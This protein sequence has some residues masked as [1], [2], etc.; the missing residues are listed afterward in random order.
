MSAP[1]HPAGLPTPQGLYHPDAERDA[2]GFGLIANLH[3]VRSHRVVKR[4]IEILAN[5]THRG[6]AGADP[7]TGDGAGILLQLPR[8]FL[9]AEAERLAIPLPPGEHAWTVG[10]AFL[11]PQAAAAQRALI[12]DALTR[13]GLAFL[14]WRRVPVDPAALGATA[15]ASLPGVE[16][17]YVGLGGLDPDAAERRLLLARRRMERAARALDPRATF[18]IPSLSARTLVYKGLLLAHQIERFYP[19]LTDER[20]D[21]ALAI[22]H[23]RYSTNTFPTWELAHPFRRMAHN[24]E[25]NTLRGNLSWMAA[26]QASLTSAHFTPDELAEILP[27]LDHARS[28]SAWFDATLELLLAAGHPLHRAIAMMIPEAWEHHDA[29]PPGLRDFYE[30]QALAI[31]PWDG[32]AAVA[33]TDGVR[34]GGVLD[35]NGLRPARYFVTEG[36]FVV[37]ASEAGVIEINEADIIARGRLQPGRLFLIDTA[38]A[39]ILTD[40]ELKADLASARPWAD[41]LAAQRLP[42]ASLPDA[43]ALPSPLDGDAPA[44]PLQVAFGYTLEDLRLILPP[45]ARDGHEAIGS[46]GDDAALACLSDRPRLLFEYF[47]QHFA[48]VTN[49]PIDSLRERLVM[50]LVS[51]L[52]TRGNPLE[53]KEKSGACVVRLEHPLL[54]AAELGRLAALDAPGFAARV[55]PTTF[56]PRHE[57]PGA[58]LDEALTA[59][60]AAALE[61]VEGGANLLILSDRGVGPGAAPIPALLATA[62]VHHALTR[63]GTRARAELIVDTGEAREVGHIALLLGFGAA[64]VHPWLAL[65]TLR[66]IVEDPIWIER[67]VT[68]AEAQRNYIH[69]IEAGFLKIFAKMGV[70]TLQSYQAAQLFEIVGLDAALV[71]RCFPGTPSR[72]SGVG[73]DVIAQEALLRHQQAY[74]PPQGEPVALDP[75]GHYQWRRQGERHTFDPD[76][77]ATLQHAVRQRSYAT[78]QEFSDLAN[79]TNEEACTLR[80]LLTFVEAPEPLPI[81]EVEPAAAI[82]RR[83]CTGA[84]SFGS[85]SKE[86]H[87]TLAQAMNRLGGRS[88]TGEGGEDAARFHDS[89]RSAIKQVASGRFG[90]TSWYLV[91]A[92]EVQIKMAQGAKPGEG[93]QLPGHKVDEEIA[94]LRHSTPGV[95]LISPP[96]HHDIYSIEDLAQLIHDLKA[97]SHG[98]Q[99]SVKLVARSGVGTIAAGVAKGK[100][101]LIVISGHDGGTGASPQTSIKYAGVPWEIG[102]AEAQQTLLLNHLR[103]RVRLQVD[104]GLKTGRDVAVAALLGADEFGF[105]TAPLVAMGCLLMRVCHLNTCP[106]GIATQDPHLRRLF[107]GQPEHVIHYMLFVAEEVRAIMARL[108]FRT[109]EEM[110]GRADRLRPAPHLQ[111]WKSKHLDFSSI[112]HQPALEGPRSH[113]ERQEHHLERD[114]DAALMAEA[115]PALEHGEEVVITR[116]IRNIHRSVGAALGAA[117]SRRWGADGLPDGTLTLDLRGSAG[118]SFAAFAPR[119]L[120]FRLEGATNDYAGK[121]LSGAR[122]IVRPDRLNTYVPHENVITGNVA[123]YGATWGEAFFCGR[124]GERFA[125][126]NSGATAVVEGVGDHGC[127]YMTGG[128]VVIL[129]STGRN[130][131]AGM[132]GGIAYVYDPDQRLPRRCNTAMVG[133][134]PLEGEEAE[135]ILALITRH[136]NLTQSPRAA[137]LIARWDEARAAFTRVIPHE[138]KRWLQR[139]QAR[140]A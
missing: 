99:V 76:V 103:G 73:L 40:E 114:L 17:L 98:A 100:A 52:G 75:G 21:T 116:R 66:G 34:V 77:V 120:T 105:S 46:M 81:E 1:Q 96:P 60:C 84:M 12:E 54:T 87:E 78:W 63:R 111:H 26:R 45:M 37:M 29:L 71:A 23:Q 11:D 13:T 25:I 51:F 91:N 119:G 61:A 9:Q 35:R 65:H 50:S 74:A 137:D 140:V 4:S 39:R 115:A 16:H 86:A 106:V 27:D 68:W 67:P 97:A 70:S 88:N 132:S 122:I 135:E 102:L 36:G 24:G 126:R 14:G 33:F 79:K 20:L 85:I 130:F 49:P 128:R 92:D 64:A 133:L 72:L 41:D 82:V 6:A 112:L 117:V 53:S 57:A 136:H 110:I 47:K 43:P 69:A 19:D 121:G 32:P 58:A 131:A 55:L 56:A 62:A 5:L 89:R 80:G 48:Q 139:Q 38:N 3:G 94:R 44:T 22:V 2:C 108:G 113:V 101:D 93:G 125:V 109:L 42:I 134:E 138:Y 118:Q 7:D 83:F 104:G 90:V 18:H 123:L 107:R 30:A 124:A 31:E 59:L 127:E 10:V 129:G 28:D 95:G 8:A 15:R